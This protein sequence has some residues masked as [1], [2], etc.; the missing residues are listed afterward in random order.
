M[1]PDLNNISW[2]WKALANE[3]KQDTIRIN[4]FDFSIRFNET[5]R[6]MEHL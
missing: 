3:F 5:L 6:F 1:T 4:V 2:I